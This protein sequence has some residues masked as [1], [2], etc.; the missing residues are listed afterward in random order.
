MKTRVYTFLFFLISMSGWSQDEWIQTNGPSGGEVFTITASPLDYLYAS[1]RMGVYRSSDNGNNWNLIDFPLGN[2]PTAV[3]SNGDV[4]AA[5]G[6]IYRSVDAGITW[7]SV[8][9]APGF[10]TNIV[11]DSAGTIYVGNV[12]WN[13]GNSLLISYDNGD[14]W[15][16]Q[17][18]E[19]GVVEHMVINVNSLG[20]IYLGTENFLYRSTDSGITWE[21]ITESLNQFVVSSI[22]ITPGDDLFIGLSMGGGIYRS[23]DYGDTLVQ[24]MMDIEVSSLT[25]NSDSVIFAGTTSG[26]YRSMNNGDA[27]EL[28]T[29]GLADLNILSLG[30]DSEDNLYAGAFGIFRSNNNGDDW[31]AAY[32]GITANRVFSIDSNQE[33]DLFAL[34]DG[35][36]R[37]LD[38]G[39]T[40]IRVNEDV[41]GATFQSILVHTNG[42]VYVPNYDSIGSLYRSTDNGDTW[43]EL[44]LNSHHIIP[45]DMAV[46]QE[47]DIFVVGEMAG[48]LRSIDNGVTWTQVINGI[49][50]DHIT[51]IALNDTGCIFI[52]SRLCDILYRSMDNGDTW[53]P[54]MNGIDPPIGIT[55]IAFNSLSTIFAGTESNVVYR[56][57][58]NGNSWE[59]LTMDIIDPHPFITDIVIDGNDNLYASS[60]VDGV[61]QSTDNGESWVLINEGLTFTSVYGLDYSTRGYLFNSTNGASVWIRD[62]DV[63][64]EYTKADSN[65][66]Q[67]YPNPATTFIQFIINTK[68]TNS[69]YQLINQYGQLVLTGSLREGLNTINI[70]QLETG[71]YLLQI[72]NAESPIVNKFV[73]K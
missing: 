12:S 41:K 51:T 69:R 57:M 30:V 52:G 33:G 29:T 14:N 48:V 39:D 67:I 1:T 56:S 43:E 24:V 60:Y 68:S 4:F 61:F 26:V 10:F 9:T 46:N 8:T 55:S 17:P 66:M 22:L 35:V 73:K 71:V 62:I 19:L 20:Y 45:Y 34:A 11:I 25:I 59:G 47:G 15:V 50:C 6:N 53:I 40:W 18:I 5:S 72:L 42:D 16:H 27:W 64:S 31:I 38:N 21:N 49:D 37:S 58:D 65:G 23:T 32:T 44:L 70:K 3:N 7:D 28:A 54:V 13:L 63:S 36:Y 2:A